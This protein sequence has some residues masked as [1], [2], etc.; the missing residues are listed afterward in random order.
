MKIPSVEEMIATLNDQDVT[1]VPEMPEEDDGESDDMEVHSIILLD[2]LKGVTR[3]ETKLD[4]M[5]N[6]DIMDEFKKVPG[7]TQNTNP[8]FDA[9]LMDN[10][11]Q[12][13]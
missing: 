1:T 10:V 11:Y 6:E 13:Y 8:T 9:I 3:I 12:S 2:I 7:R 5:K 4:S